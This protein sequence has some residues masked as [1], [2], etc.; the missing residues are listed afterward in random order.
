MR[1]AI[2]LVLATTLA[3]VAAGASADQLAE[4]PRTLVRFAEETLVDFGRDPAVVAA[5]ESQNARNRSLD[6]IKAIDEE[7]RETDG[8]TRFMLDLMSNECALRILNYEDTYGFIVE[9]FVMDG[10]GANV[11]QS[12]KTSDYWQGDEAKFIESYAG[13]RG[14]IHYGDIEYDSSV[15]E[16]LI[17]VSVPVVDGER[18]I[19]AVTFG[20]SLDRWERR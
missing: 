4:V 1:R 20:I 6:R 5:V 3:L 7:W 19:G 12:E 18:A 16:V 15:G 2:V 10:L 11:A 13:G 8:V 9:T 14:A 17:Q